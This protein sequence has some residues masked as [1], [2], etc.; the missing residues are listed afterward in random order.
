ML[1]DAM[2]LMQLQAGDEASFEAFEV[3]FLRHYE[4]IYGILFRLLGHKADAEDVAQQVFLKL[5][6]SNSQRIGHFL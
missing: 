3:L 4:Q 1:S 6:H 5:Y 2:L